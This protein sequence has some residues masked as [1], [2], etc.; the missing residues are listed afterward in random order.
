MV[1]SSFA[2]DASAQPLLQKVALVTGSSRG[3]GRGIALELARQGASLVL[4]GRDEAL[5]SQVLEETRGL[6]R[7]AMV[8]VLDLREPKAAEELVHGAVERFGR[9][10]IVVNNAGATK[11]GDFTA[12]SEGD[13]QDG[14]A[15]KFFG[16]VRVSRA[17]WPHLKAQRGSL[18]Q[19]AGVGGRTPGAEFA[20]GGSVNAAL[21]SLTKALADT[22]VA[23]GI[24]VNAINPGFIR[25]D[26]LEKRLAAL[27]AKRGV[28][29]AEAAGVMVKEAQVNRLGEVEDIAHLVAFIVSPQGSFLHGSVIDMDGGQTKTL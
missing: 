20:I 18:V 10:D 25:T 19:I 13:W 22:G 11:R 5:L 17:A 12:L 27:A 28:S 1:P 23:D 26:R 21:L 3:I 24:R 2:P 15:L 6:G 14:F 9:L 16:A 4:T 29:L 7:E 8:S